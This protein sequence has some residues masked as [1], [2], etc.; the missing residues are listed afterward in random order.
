[1]VERNTC[2]AVMRGIVVPPGSIQ[3][4]PL[5]A[6]ANHSSGGGNNKQF[7]LLSLKKYRIQVV[8]DAP[9]EHNPQ[10]SSVALRDSR[11]LR[12]QG[13]AAFHSAACAA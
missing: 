12:P 10:R 11:I 7:P 5:L 13:G 6:Q 3:T 2:D 1:M 4:N 9:Q 8:M